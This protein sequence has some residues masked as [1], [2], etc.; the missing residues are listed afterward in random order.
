V[1]E[2]SSFRLDDVKVFVV[3]D[4]SFR[5][6][7]QVAIYDWKTGRS[8]ARRNERQLACY[9]F[10]AI[11]KWGVRPDQIRTVEFNL[12]SGRRN[13]HRLTANDLDSIRQY[14]RGSARDMRFLLE[15]AP[16][17]VAREERFLFA[18]NERACRFC[19]FRKA[20]PQW[21]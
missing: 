6:G 1:E 14:I 11:E 5:D 10:Y 17:N 16:A 3:L 2:F 21:T 4:F 7:D 15:D 12:A 9:S 8:G 13:E 20:C 19:N 18:E